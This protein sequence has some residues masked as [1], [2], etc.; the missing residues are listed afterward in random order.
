MQS[1]MS[2]VLVA[3]LCAVVLCLSGCSL[4]G[5]DEI[6]FSDLQRQTREFMG[7]YETIKLTPQQEAVKKTALE[8]MP[9][10]CCSEYSAYTCCCECNISRTIWGLSNYMIAKQGASAAQVTAKVKEWISFVNPKGFQGQACSTGGCPRP[11]KHG[12]CGG[13]NPG[14]V[15]F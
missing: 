1:R 2:R 10:P 7:W 4:V 5:A 8:A 6:Q 15:A 9:A 13:M 14:S 3:G 11:F 12:G